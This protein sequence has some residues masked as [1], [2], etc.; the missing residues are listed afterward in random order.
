MEEVQRALENISTVR[1][2]NTPGG[3]PGISTERGVVN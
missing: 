3:G 1:S 2:N